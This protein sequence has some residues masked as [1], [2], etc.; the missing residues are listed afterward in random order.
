MKKMAIII[1][2]CMVSFCFLGCATTKSG[3]PDPI[4]SVQSWDEWI[5]EN[6]W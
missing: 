5:K 3:Q 4:K 2:F 1:L 6:M